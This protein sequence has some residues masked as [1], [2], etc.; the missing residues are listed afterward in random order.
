MSL[1]TPA[2]Q[3]IMSRWTV[4]RCL[5]RICL[6]SA[7]WLTRMLPTRTIGM[8]ILLSLVYLPAN[9]KA[10]ASGTSRRTGVAAKSKGL[11]SALS[12]SPAVQTVF[13][14]DIRPFV[15]KYCLGCHSGSNAQANINLA[16]YK[17]VAGVLKAGS[18]WERVAQNVASGHM[19]PVGS[20]APT[21][22]HRDQFTTWIQ[23]TLSAAACALHDP[24]HVTLRRLNR[25][26]YNN[27]VR[28]LCGVDIHPA[29]AFP[30]DDVGYGFDNIG[31]VLSLSPLLMEKY[32]SAAQQVAH[33]AFQNPD[34]FLSPTAFGPADLAYIH[35]ADRQNGTDGDHAS[36]YATNS[37][38][39]ADYHF[40]QEG[41]YLLRAIAWQDRAGNEPAQMQLRL[42]GKALVTVPVVNEGRDHRPY[43]VRVRVSAG[44]H[45]FSAV[46]LNDFYDGSTVNYDKSHRDRNLNVQALEIVGPL[47][48]PGFQSLLTKQLGTL[49][50]AEALRTGI[51][52]KFLSDFARRAYRRPVTNEEVTK[53]MRFVEQAHNE[54]EPFQQGIEN[55][56]TAAMCSP[57]FLFHL[58]AYSPAPAS[59][60]TKPQRSV[61]RMKSS[62]DFTQVR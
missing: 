34:D 1:F 22:P 5:L 30:N 60:F 47:H 36:L 49:E 48:P 16:L 43:A 19:P 18:L 17:D 24:G 21:Q 55:A 51:A 31:D 57:Y 44:Q 11:P 59:T 15:Q 32:M 39:G 42:D 62:K 50:P 3:I 2:Q 41:D 61:H 53:L 26:E 29:D 45:R 4:D 37:E 46:F 23:T 56:M 27:T 20:P 14:R 6:A 12:V 25:A 58:E 28:D 33:A 13:T 35:E 52:R 40:P 10:N 9:V 7:L 8:T 38:A 54:G